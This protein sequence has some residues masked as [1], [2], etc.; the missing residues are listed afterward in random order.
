MSDEFLVAVD[1]AIKYLEKVPDVYA[2]KTL[3]CPIDDKISEAISLAMSGTAAQR[4]MFYS[5]IT[6]DVASA[7]HAFAH[8]MSM[9]SVRR[10]SESLLLQGL[11]VTTMIDS[12]VDFR[13]ILMVLSLLHNSVL[14]LGLDVS[15]FF[16]RVEQ[17]APSSSSADR[18]LSFPEREPKKKSIEGMGF[19]EVEGPSGLVYWS[20]SGPIYEGLLHEGEYVVPEDVEDFFTSAFG[21]PTFYK[22]ELE[23]YL[24]ARRRVEPEKHAW[25]ED[26]LL[27][28][29]EMGSHDSR[30]VLVL[31]GLGTERARVLLRERLSSRPTRF[32]VN[33]A[34]ALWHVERSLEAFHRVVDVLSQATDWSTRSTAATALRHFR[35][36][37]AVQALKEAFT[38]ENGTVR[39]NAIRSL[40]ALHGLPHSAFDWPRLGS[41]V[42]VNTPKARQEWM[43]EVDRLICDRSLP[44]CQD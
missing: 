7:L 9:L 17:Y 5:R 1:E 8:R 16:K 43:A 21:N 36:R 20:G 26:A 41:K 12:K 23:V 19:R 4:R 11:V 38:D 39:S 42:R 6:P 31:G 3:P 37:E 24:D 32:L 44:P 28:A 34:V 18:T 10:Q 22:D 13:H 15:S 25:A 35:C 2:Q 14:K 40:L 33:V 29:L 27:R 30:V